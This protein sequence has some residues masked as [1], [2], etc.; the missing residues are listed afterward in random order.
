MALTDAEKAARYRARH[1][2]R[3]KASKAKYRS[4]DKGS[5]TERDYNKSWV[6][7]N[8]DKLNA[9]RRERYATDEEYRA[10]VNFRNNEAQKANRSRVNSYRSERRK[11]DP[12]FKL[13]HSI[14][15][16]MRNAIRGK[17]KRTW[18]SMVGYTAEDLRIHLEAQFEP[19]MNWDNYGSE[20]HIDH[21]RPVASFDLPSEVAD[22]WSLANLRPLSALENMSKK[23]RI[24]PAVIPDALMPKERTDME[25]EAQ[26]LLD[27]VAA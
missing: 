5:Q 19:W 17:A 8:R 16:Q 24:D 1:P 23:D 2:E 15:V 9:R 25:R 12:T 13:Q 10:R 22:C 11:T 18:K 21:R 20:W 6:V 4:G 14:G 3:A 26:K 7:E 27:K